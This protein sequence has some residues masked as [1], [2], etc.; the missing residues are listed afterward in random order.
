M[1]NIFT[2]NLE[3]KSYTLFISSI[4]KTSGTNN[5]SSFNVNWDDFLPKEW[6][7]Y[8]MTFAFQSGGGYYKDSSFTNNSNTG[9]GGT[10]TITLT[11]SGSTGTPVVGMIIT[12]SN[13]IPTNTYI[14]AVGIAGTT[15]VITLSKNL[16]GALLGINLVGTIVFNGCKIVMNTSSKNFSFDTSSYS[17]SYTIGYGQRDIQT[18]TSSSNSFSAFYLQFP[19]KSIS[20]PSNNTLTISIYNINNNAL[21]TDTNSTGTTAL[22]DMT[23]WNIILEFVPIPESRQYKMPY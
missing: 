19:P 11:V 17:P 1:S 21:L 4:D 6:N 20:R 15:Q 8:K 7:E 13:F 18:A 3:T 14:T 23:P 9:T 22:T 12:G 5:Q 2:N 10:N 16:T